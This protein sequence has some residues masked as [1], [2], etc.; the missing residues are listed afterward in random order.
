M[1]GIKTWL[2]LQ[3]LYIIISKNYFY[4]RSCVRNIYF[5]GIYKGNSI[6]VKT[7][8]V[9]PKFSYLKE[10]VNNSFPSSF[11]FRTAEDIS[12]GIPVLLVSVEFSILSLIQMKAF[13][14]RDYRPDTRKTT[15]ML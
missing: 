11:S 6:L 4:Y 9:N 3:T 10:L 13:R 15:P 14:Y 2:F 5:L 1:L 7:I 8:K 12:T